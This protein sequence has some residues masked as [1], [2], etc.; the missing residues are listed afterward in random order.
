[1]EV[2]IKQ[3]DHEGHEAIDVLTKVGDSMPGFGIVDW[4]MGI[5]A[6]MQKLDEGNKVV[7]M[8]VAAA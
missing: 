5:V 8:S 4:V 3:T 2:Q 6:T 1:M 7:G